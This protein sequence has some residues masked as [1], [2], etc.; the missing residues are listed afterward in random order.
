MSFSSEETIKKIIEEHLP[1]REKEKG[2]LGE[3]FTP[4]EMINDLLDGFPPSIFKDKSLKWLDP[5]AGIGNFP[6]TLFYRLME[7]IDIKSPQTRA[8]H[9]IEKMLYMVEI[10]GENVK[11]CKKIFAKIAPNTKLNIY[12]DDFL[13][14]AKNTKDRFDCVLGNPPYNVG[15]TKLEGKKRFHI[16]FTEVGLEILNPKGYLAYICPPSYREKGTPMNKLFQEANGHF[17]FIKI[18]GAEETMRLFKIQGRVDSVVYQTRVK[19]NTRIIDEYGEPFNTELDLNEHIPN[20]GF[21]I[22]QK[23][24]KAVKRLGHIEAFRNTEMSTIK[25]DSF[26][27]GKHRVIHLIVKD[28]RRVYK[29][30]KGSSYEKKPKI[31]LNGLGVPYVYYDKEGKYSPSQSPVIILEPTDS[32]ANFL[33]SDLFCFIVWGL[34][35]TG[36]NNLPYLFDMV[37]DVRKTD[38]T[39][40]KDEDFKKFIGLTEKEIKFIRE[41]FAAPF[42]VDKDLLE[43]C[44]QKRKTRKIKK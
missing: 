16:I 42:S 14:F 8:K 44:S 9:I 28:G 35:I 22:F 5:S 34:R 37:P 38:F 12:E 2:E 33:K 36:N 13:E 1:I 4:I 10:N 11:Q 24:K 39:F 3:V 7:N 21:S 19:G 30:S 29:A 6:I 40:V 18:Y 23:L 17:E 31:L 26:G 43:S 25:A 20:F 15:G 32:L 41:E 27:C